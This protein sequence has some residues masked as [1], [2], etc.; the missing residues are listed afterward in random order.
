MLN[1]ANNCNLKEKINRVSTWLYTPDP[2]E[3]EPERNS[4]SINIE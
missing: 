4:E 2:S 1:E 3:N